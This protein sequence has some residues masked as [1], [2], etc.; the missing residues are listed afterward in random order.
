MVTNTRK[1][2]ILVIPCYY[3]M[4]NILLLNVTVY[5]NYFLIRACVFVCRLYFHCIQLEE[6]P[7]LNRFR[8]GNQELPKTV[9]VIK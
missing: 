7:R 5:I 9:N 3:W 8:I 1:Y 4:Y 2:M 6:N